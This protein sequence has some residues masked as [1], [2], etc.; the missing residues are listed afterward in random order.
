MWCHQD[1][2]V[3]LRQ[4]EHALQA[5]TFQVAGQQ[6]AVAGVAYF[7]HQ[8]AGVFVALRAGR[9]RVQHLQRHVARSETVACL[10]DARRDAAA[11]QLGE[12]VGD[13]LRILVGERRRASHLANA[14]TVEQGRQAIEVVEV[15]MRPDS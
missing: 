11:L 1:I 12:R 15:G 4:G 7:Q 6:Q 14:E 9:R 3:S 13:A 10:D 2:H 8:A 5:G